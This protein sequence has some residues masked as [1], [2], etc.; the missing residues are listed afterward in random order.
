MNK[1]KA[2]FAAG[3]IVVVAGASAALWY[4]NDSGI[5]GNDSTT[6]HVEDYENDDNENDVV[7]KNDAQQ[8]DNNNEQE[9]TTE[10]TDVN[11]NEKTEVDESEIND[12]L[13]VFS[14]V[15][16]AE[17]GK[18]FDINKCSDYELI[19]FAYS[20]IRSTDSSLITLEQREDNIKYYNRVSV[21]EINEVLDK[22]F[23]TSV[24]A[25]SVFTENDYA[26]FDYDD[27]YFYTPAT[28]G[29][30][31]INT[32]TADSVEQDEDYIT[33]KFTVMSDDD[34]YADGEAE[35]QMKNEEMKLV[36]YRIYN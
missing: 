6:N 12:F 3:M 15:Y 9:K 8:D 36:Y 25:E 11:E 24:P 26:F 17:Q 22:Y 23:D 10:K 27:G 5:I 18:A 4:L 30:A 20:H 28:D 13:S 33:V 29:L 16:F 31:Y 7:N 19:L 1:A 14:K 34:V 32:A 21:D 35:I 2:I